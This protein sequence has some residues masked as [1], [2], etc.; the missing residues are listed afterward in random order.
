MHHLGGLL[1]AAMLD[2]MMELKWL[3]KQADT[4][5]VEFTGKGK[6]AFAEMTGMSAT[7]FH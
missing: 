2:R 3:H 1:G 7:S 4:R 5:S 6:K